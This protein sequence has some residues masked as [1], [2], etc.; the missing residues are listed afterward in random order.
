[1]MVHL[2][3]LL[4]PL[5]AFSFFTSL[6]STESIFPDCSTGPLSKN[7]VCDTSL[8]PV[9][10]AKSLVAAMTL[11]EKINNTK[12]DSSGA[13]RLGLPAYNWWNEALHGVAEGHGVSFSDSGNFSYATSFPM[14]ILLGAAFDDDLVKQVATVIS[15]EARAFANGGH[16]GLDYWT[17]NINPFRD[18]RWGRGQ[19]TP[20]E[21]PLHLSRYVYHLV[22]GL[23][24]GIGPERPKVVATC[25]HF[26][27]YDLE[28]W[29][30]IERYAFDA[31]VSSQDLSEYYLPPFKT[32]TRD[33]KVDAVMCS[34]NSLNGIPTCADRWL[35]QTL[36]REH[37]G[38]EQTGHWVTG[39][40]GAIDNIYADHHYVADG[41]H[42]AAAALN[43]GTDLDCGS[44]FPEYLGSALQQGLYNNQTLNNALIRL[45]SS[46]VKLGYFDPADD[47]P[48]RS[49]G[50]NEV[51]TPAAEELAHKATV[52]GIVMLKN[53]GTLPLKSNGTVAIIGPFANATTQLQGNYEGPPKYIRTL[54]WAAAHNGYKVK[55]SQGTDINSNS[56]A[57]FAEAISAAKEADIVIYAGGI[58][59]TIEKESQDRTTIVWPGNQ[60]D[61]IEQLSGLKKPL[62]V[63]QFGGGQVDDSSLLANAGVGALL[64]AGYPSQAGGA[65]VFD[66]LTGKSAPAGRLPVTQYPASYVDEVPMTDMT[67]RPGSNNPGRTYRWYDKAVLPFGFGLHYTT[68]NVSWDHDE[69]GPYNTD[70]VASGS[71][72]APVDTE[73]FD[74]F[75][76]TVT[77]TGKLTSDY[78]ALLF[79]TADGVGPEPYPIKTLVGYS[80]AKG[81]KPG[82][83]QQVQLDVSVG[84]VARTAENGDLG[85]YPGSYKLEVDVGQDFPTATFTV[86]GKEK[87]LDEFPAPQQ[88]ATSAVTRR[89]R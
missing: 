69:Y 39:D 5:A 47:Q 23:Q 86:S 71:T 1:M 78:I 11:E 31:V 20:G 77:N 51:F 76:I 50:W 18:P 24:D 10:R 16:A 60:L 28:N 62:I 40:C 83:S 43:A 17:P 36:L 45:Y 89:G 54:I 6:A 59:N 19:E 27:A 88:N 64:W 22:D 81:I 75:S 34:Y 30:G 52:E 61:L 70:S 68:F 48:Y 74:T 63:V 25:K 84:S 26:A 21:D 49:I 35:L 73:L 13:P 14:P 9:S 55:F 46:L 29:E 66:I 12:Y 42:A 38:W 4:R 87:V 65:A 7:N 32:C 79:L 37:W 57:G 56:S 3:H 53:D 8:D 58:D 41:A 15:T 72:S 33:A 80:R 67:L 44:V 2:S 85:L 82:Q